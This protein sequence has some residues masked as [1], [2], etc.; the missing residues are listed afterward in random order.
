MHWPEPKRNAAKKAGK[1]RP[2]D[3][4]QPHFDRKN[5]FHS[6]DFLANR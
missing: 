1:L 2:E 5:V 4:K 3:E 6:T